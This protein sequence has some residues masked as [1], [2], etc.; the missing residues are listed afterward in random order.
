MNYVQTAIPEVWVIEP[1]VHGDG[2]GY[3]ME[4]FSQSAFERHIGKVCFIQDNESF[5]VR[6]VLR[7]LHYQLAPYAQ[8]KLVRV[9]KGVVWDVA[10]DIRRESPTFGRYVAVELSGENKKQLFVPRGFAH[11]FQVLSDEALFT[12]KVD[13]TYSPAHERSI[14]FDDP[15]VGIEWNKEALEDCILSDKDMRAPL[16][17]DAEINIDYAKDDY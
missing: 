16:L 7:G 6:G 5:S 15:V 13:N 1:E 17:S 9:I 4:A 12:Y 14:R 11:G 3:F 10:V 8:A 2:R